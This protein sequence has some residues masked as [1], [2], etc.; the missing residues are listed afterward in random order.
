MIEKKRIII[1]VSGGIAAYKSCYMASRL[2]HMGAEVRVCMTE[3]ACHFVTP[4]TFESLTHNAVNTD[5]FSRETP[6][7]VTHIALAEW[8]D[9]IIVAPATA[10]LIGKAANGICDD[11]LSTVLMAAKA[12]VFYAPAMNT[13]MYENPALQKNL[14]V[15]RS[16]GAHIIEPAEG[17][18]AC[19]TSGKGRMAEPEEIIGAVDAFFDEKKRDMAGV[20]VVVSAGATIEDID[21][22][23]FLSNRSSGKMGCAIAREACRRGAA[24]TL[25]AGENVRFS[26]A[27]ID[28]VFVRSAADMH[29]AVTEAGKEADVVVM[30][31][32]VADYTPKKPFDGKIKKSAD[33]MTIELSRTKDILKE[34]GEHKGERILV[35]FAAEADDMERYAKDKLKRKNL[36]MIVAN[37]ISR[38]DIGFGTQE[39]EV[40]LYYKDGSSS[41]I[42]KCGKDIVAKRILDDVMRMMEDRND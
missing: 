21:K 25:V 27:D 32:A 15:L 18:L 38:K 39:N 23:R 40:T 31:A 10:N 30:A 7:N 4:L 12:P 13:N 36:D 33:D 24:V 11:L 1:G 14:E 6:M 5:M 16:R 3:S 22:V 37:D 19:G 34:L 17:A 28:V 2:I 42:D 35:G 29:W 20:K 26:D 8:A 9:A 41:S